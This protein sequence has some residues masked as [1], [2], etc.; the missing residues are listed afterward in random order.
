MV[1][2]SIVP[3]EVLN[4]F[5]AR[6]VQIRMSGFNCVARGCGVNLNGD[7]GIVVVRGEDGRL[8]FV[9]DHP[10]CRA[11]AE[12]QGYEFVTPIDRMAL[13]KILGLVTPDGRVSEL[14]RHEARVLRKRPHQPR[15]P[16]QEKNGK[17]DR[18]V[19]FKR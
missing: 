16:V 11:Q 6:L 19:F 14:T 10:R 12:K 15:V 5:D 9:C 13:A 3:V 4:Q 18:H 1:Q 17:H 7:E 8:R 2:S